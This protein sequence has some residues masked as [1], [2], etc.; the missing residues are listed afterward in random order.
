[1]SLL[2]TPTC[3]FGSKAPHFSLPDVYGQLVS[4][5]SVVGKGGLVVAFICNHCP[6]VVAQIQDFV[7]DSKVF[8][9]MG[10]NTVAIM[11][12]DF[13]AYPDDS[14]EKMVSFSHGHNFNFPYL[15]DEN[16]IAARA[17]GAVCTP[18]YFGFNANLEL[19]YRGRLDNLRMSRDGER[20]PEL[21]NAIREVDEGRKVPKNQLSSMGCSI[22]WK[23]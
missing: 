5:D 19:V 23:R 13:H 15:L 8:K 14:P 18:D 20:I 1:M 4:S 10:V 9:A 16:Q 3:A 11:S 6:Y 7:S 21:V 2:E 17:Y 12:N 22:K